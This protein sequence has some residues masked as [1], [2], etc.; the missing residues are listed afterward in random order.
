METVE[1]RKRGMG[2]RTKTIIMFSA[3][4]L[5]ITIITI[6]AVRRYLIYGMETDFGTTTEQIAAGVSANIDTSAL[7]RVESQAVEVYSSIPEDK[8]FESSY[9]GTD[10]WYEYL[11]Y[12]DPITK[13][14]DYRILM[15]YMKRSLDALDVEDVYLGTY[16]KDPDTGEM[17]YMYLVD[18]V[19]GEYKCPIGVFE[20]YIELPD[21]F[22]AHPEIGLDTYVT[23]TDEYG[24]LMTATTAVVDRNGEVCGFIGVDM[25]MNAIMARI[26]S[27][28]RTIVILIIMIAALFGVAYVMV[29]NRMLIR[30]INEL[31][32]AAADFVNDSEKQEGS[33]FARLD[34][35]SKDEIGNLFSSMKQMEDDIGEYI[36]NITGL[37]SEK[38]KL[39]A[40]MKIAWSIQ[41]SILPSDFE[42]FSQKNH[43]E[44]FA[45]MT[46][47]KQV[48]GDFYD[49]FN[50][51]DTH[52]GL[53]IAD[54]S[55][56]GIP[57]SLFMAVSKTAL[58]L[59]ALSGGDA[60]TVLSDVN[61]WLCDNNDSEQFVTALFGI[62]DLKTGV[63]Q[64]SNAGH[65][66]PVIIS[67]DHVSLIQG[68]NDPP[69][70]AIPFC[71]FENKEI[72][73]SDGDILVLYTDG[74]PEAK[75]AAGERFGMERIS[76]S[77]KGYGNVEARAR[78]LQDDVVKFTGD[79]DIFDDITLLCVRFS[80]KA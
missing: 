47:A 22:L 34:I 3:V 71:A 18:P 39:N 77:L 11:S 23:R 50:I 75:N 57:A 26:N 42:E 14:E 25:S 54:V 73:L 9:W 44:T 72:T 2:I 51:D 6:L 20:M 35:R 64:Y 53:V 30:P 29:I 79:V 15:D 31:S 70:A 52:V 49:Y 62:L 55:G 61:T 32:K 33:V 80:E 76:A 36:S 74:I 45:L 66:Y 24:W 1:T 27:F 21:G 4:V 41:S 43:L 7:K 69:L 40:E 67:G 48:G 12:F 28:I 37:T 5:S 10:E 59:R 63:M 19:E 78:R 46:P 56:K 38:E 16:F 65:E 17:K 13:T 8:R 58:Q 60:K 68:D